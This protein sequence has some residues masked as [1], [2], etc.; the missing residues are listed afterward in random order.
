MFFFVSYMSNIFFA[1]KIHK[2]SRVIQNNNKAKDYFQNNFKIFSFLVVISGSVYNS[3]QIT[4][5]KLYGLRIFDSGLKKSDL[6][7]FWIYKIIL[8]TFFENV[9]EFIL[10]I[11]YE[12]FWIFLF[13]FFCCIS[14]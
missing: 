1:L 5:C 10:Q 12:I 13:L 3:I 14:Y 9:P 8:V 2:S 6:K 4:A 11:A 7:K